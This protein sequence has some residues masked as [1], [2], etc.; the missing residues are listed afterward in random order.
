MIGFLR[1]FPSSTLS[2]VLRNG[3]Q[4]DPAGVEGYV[5]IAPSSNNTNSQ[6]FPRYRVRREEIM[7]LYDILLLSL[8]QLQIEALYQLRD[9][10]VD[11]CIC[12]TGIVISF[13]P[14]D[15]RSDVALLNAETRPRS[16]SK[17][18][19]V[20]LQPFSVSRI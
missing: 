3:C 13:S 17:R 19:Q 14:L 18:Y 16:T 6:S 9:S 7:K 10:N 5:D 11:L 1:F 15:P 2:Y 4:C 8:K 20:L 12:K